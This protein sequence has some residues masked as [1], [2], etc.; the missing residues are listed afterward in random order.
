MADVA[1]NEMKITAGER[2]KMM[3]D[4]YESAVTG[5]RYDLK[6]NTDTAVTYNHIFHTILQIFI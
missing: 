6:T 2:V 1:Y 4:I 3:V 5:G